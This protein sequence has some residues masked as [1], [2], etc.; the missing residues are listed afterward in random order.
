MSQQTLT[1]STPEKFDPDA[2]L[3]REWCTGTDPD[4]AAYLFK[5]LADR[6]LGWIALMPTIGLLILTG[7]MIGM[8]IDLLIRSWFI[9]LLGAALGTGAGA[10]FFTLLRRRNFTWHKWLHAMLPTKSLTTSKISYD[11]GS[12]FMAAFFSIASMVGVSLTGHLF[13]GHSM[14]PVYVFLFVLSLILIFGYYRNHHITLVEW[15]AGSIVGV[16]VGMFFGAGFAQLVGAAMGPLNLIASATIVGMA[17]GALIGLYIGHWLGWGLLT[18]LY[19]LSILIV[20]ISGLNPTLV[21]WLSGFGLGSVISSMGLFFSKPTSML[22]FDRAYDY[23]RLLFWWQQRPATLQLEAA[24]DHYAET[25]KL[26]KRLDDKR[27]ELPAVEALLD[28]LGSSDWRKRFIAW[29]LL[30]DWGGEVLP[31]LVSLLFNNKVGPTVHWLIKSIGHETTTRL[32]HRAEEMINPDTGTCCVRQAVRKP[33]DTALITHYYGCR[34]TGRSRGLLHCP[35]GVVAVLDEGGSEDFSYSNG[36]LRVNW[37][38]RQ[39]LFDFTQIEIVSA[40]EEA[41][42][43]FVVQVGNDTDPLR[44]GRYPSMRCKLH[45]P[46]SDNNLRILERTFGEVI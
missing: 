44:R 40:P 45:G 39:E 17:T 19:L 37:L 11:I 33:S 21:G 4:F 5:Y 13:W 8:M 22:P 2:I 24:L 7:G 6:P 1:T 27:R 32:G 18:A 25:A 10:A 43:R 26:L 41:I 20:L 42:E 36:Q 3:W 9:T 14:I 16:I 34:M 29:F 30:V 31:E 46:V 38:V 23:R 35:Q 28:N 15:G 12:V